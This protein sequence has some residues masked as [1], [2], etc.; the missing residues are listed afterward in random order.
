MQMSSATPPRSAGIDRRTFLMAGAAAATT[1]FTAS[2]FA[3]TA[4]PAAAAAI[5][6]RTVETNGAKIHFA[7]QGSGPLVLLCH[8]WPELWVSWKHQL[9]ALAAAG[10]HAV[11]PD[12]RGY[13]DSAVPTDTAAY[14]ILDMVGDLTGLIG[15]LGERKAII[16]GH[17]W[18]AIVAW[19]AAQLRPDLFPA[20]V[21][22]SAPY[23]R[24][25]PVP[26]LEALR[27]A[28]QEHNYLLY[29]QTPGVAEAE[30]ER[31]V[32][33]TFR[34]L[35][36]SR[37]SG[38]LDIPPGHSFLELFPDPEQLPG[39]LTEQDLAT[40]VETYRRTGFRGGLNYYRNIDR[41]WA[42]LASWQDQAVRQPALFIA[43]S[44]DGIVRSPAGQA[45]LA[46]LDQTV[47]G[48]K[49]KVLIDGAGHWIQRE[50]PDEVNKALIDFLRT[51][52]A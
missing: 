38:P 6:Q 22:M 10:F 41:N 27:R 23:R 8:G 33:T 32:P 26:P 35:F 5:V 29:F 1:N 45:A 21:A 20:V 25:T 12:M 51:L 16:V 37:A 11:A 24:R 50:R 31:D 49:G 7:E 42:L 43:G 44:L 30:F 17:D 36:G 40:Y 13:G 18:G 9:P 48:L 34:R 19:A 52:P 39:W 3:Q 46:Q 28:G 2:A 47:P 14:S 15:A 4:A